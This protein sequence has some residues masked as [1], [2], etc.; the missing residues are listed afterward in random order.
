MNAV[1]KTSTI[2]I[3]HDRCDVSKW[4]IAEWR[5]LAAFVK[6]GGLQQAA[7]LSRLGMQLVLSMHHEPA[8]GTLE[9]M[10]F[11][12]EDQMPNPIITDDLAEIAGDLEI[13]PI[14]PIYRGPTKYAVKF[15][16]AGPDGEHD[17]YEHEIFESEADAQAFLKSLLEPAAPG[18][19]QYTDYRP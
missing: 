15:G 1:K 17:G 2:T 8:G 10:G 19:T 9:Q 13:T 3:H 7:A 11:G 12:E 18:Y 14:V 5:T 6:D 4:T 16:T